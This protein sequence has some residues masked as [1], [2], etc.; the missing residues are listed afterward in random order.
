MRKFVKGSG[1]QASRRVSGLV[2]QTG[3]GEGGGME[4]MMITHPAL[5]TTHLGSLQQPN[6]F[7]HRR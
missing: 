7:P 2:C 1:A 4:G 3:E 6:P 5:F